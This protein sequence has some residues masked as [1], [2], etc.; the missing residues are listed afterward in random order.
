ME[1]RKYV[2][3]SLERVRPDVILL[4]ETKLNV[5]RCE[6]LRGWWQNA[7]DLCYVPVVHAAGGILTMWI[8]AVYSCESFVLGEGF[9]L[10]SLRVVQTQELVVICNVYGP[11]DIRGCERMLT[12][13]GVELD[14]VVTRV[15]VGGDF[16]AILN[17]GLL[18]VTP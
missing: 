4:Q 6:S 16:N 11:Q 15:V 8:K 1:K 18:I 2:W 9:L 3:L 13:M 10:V 5:E 12:E 14:D 17:D 7:M